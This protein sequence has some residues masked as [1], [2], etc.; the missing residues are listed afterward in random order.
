MNS[1]LDRNDHVRAL[2]EWLVSRS[3]KDEV[4]VSEASE[5]LGLSAKHVREALCEIG[6]EGL[7][8]TANRL[9]Y[10]TQN[11]SQLSV[12]LVGDHARLFLFG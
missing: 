7:V 4:T 10:S 11:L 2:V 8:V 12:K 6:E 9:G 3:E 1:I 5:S